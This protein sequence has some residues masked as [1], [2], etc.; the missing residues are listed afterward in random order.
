[1]KRFFTL[2]FAVFMLLS[3]ACAQRVTVIGSDVAHK[4]RSY[5]LNT[6]RCASPSGTRYLYSASVDDGDT[7]K[8]EMDYIFSI[9]EDRLHKTTL[10]HPETVSFLKCYS[11][12]DGLAAFYL[13]NNRKTKV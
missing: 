10:S 13:D 12:E 7:K 4:S 8:S 6:H 1:M 9:E 3:V 2:S 5:L 11:N